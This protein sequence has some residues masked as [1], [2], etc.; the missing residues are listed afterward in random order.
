MTDKA[1]PAAASGDA[2]ETGDAATGAA[3]EAG[4]AGTEAAGTSTSGSK[5]ITL[6]QDEFDAIVERRLAKERRDNASTAEKAAKWDQHVAESASEA[7]KAEA[8]A[9]EREAAI[10]DREARAS[11]LLKRAAVLGAVKAASI[12]TEFED[13]VVD[14]LMGADGVEVTDEGEVAGVKEAL[15]DLLAKRPKL[16]AAAPTPSAQGGE[17]GGQPTKTVDEKIAELIAKGDPASMRESRALKL[18]KYQTRAGVGPP[19]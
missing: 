5:P 11:E 18:Q 7:E 13:L 12:E 1:N 15:K 4:T 17:F 6:T 3:P 8:K 14:A 10:A 19:A 2:G 16:K 9:K